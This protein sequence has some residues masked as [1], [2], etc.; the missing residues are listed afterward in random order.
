MTESDGHDFRTDMTP[1]AVR[2]E[3]DG[4]V[5]IITIDRPERRNAISIGV[6]DELDAALESLAS[7]AH[8]VVITGGGDRVFVSG[9]D[10]KELAEVR[11]LEGA[12]AMAL[13]MRRVCD[14]IADFPVPVIA[15]LNGSALGGGAELAVACDMR[16]AA[17]DVQFGFI[18]ARLGIMPAWGGAE[19]LVA[20]VGSARAFYLMLSARVLGAE[21]LFA[22]GL[23]EEVIARESFERRW[24][25]L[26]QLIAGVAPGA[27]LGIKQL[28]RRSEAPLRPGTEDLAVSMFAKSWVSDDHWAAAKAMDD[29]RRDRRG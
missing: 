19:R 8:V 23:A 25:E 17:D 2:V 12:S 24:R 1:G 22:W 27:R 6:M 10:L 4:S 28:G 11:S 26:A 21:E 15:A 9:G 13:K 16:I 14:K 7:S 3:L 5:G 18:Q 20:L 29:L